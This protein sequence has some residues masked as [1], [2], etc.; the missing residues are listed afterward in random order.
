M[1]DVTADK[2]YS[3]KA[4]ASYVEKFGAAP[5][6]PFLSTHNL[7]QQPLALEMASAWERMSHLFAFNRDVFLARYHQRSNVE[8]T[9]SMIK[10]KF[11]DNLRS[12]SDV[13]QI[14]AVLCKV[15]AHNLCCVI[16]AIH[17][18]GLESPTFGHALSSQEAPCS[19]I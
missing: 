5:V 19:A 12:K 14:N 13:G 8:T 4:N 10:R 18:L 6:I 3:N 1:R 2:A 11:G 16:A 9:F 7:P 15:I 17:E